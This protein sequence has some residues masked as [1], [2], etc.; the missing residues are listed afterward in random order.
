[1]KLY[2]YAIPDR[3]DIL[4]D[5]MI[6]FTQPAAFNDP[7]EMSPY[8]AAIVSEDYIAARMA[9]DHD[10]HVAESYNRLSRE[11]RRKISFKQYQAHFS[12]DVM[13]KKL[14]EKALGPALDEARESLP[15]AINQAL[16]IL[17]LTETSDDLLM[18]AHYA[19]S[20]SGMVLEFDSE[21]D[22]FVRQFPEGTNVNPV[23]FDEDLRKDYGFLRHIDYSKD[24]PAL[25]ISDVKS[26]AAFLVKSCEWSY[27]R[28]WR[29]L[30][31]FSYADKKLEI[32]GDWPVC[33]FAIPL[34]AIT[35][36]I[37]GTRAEP[38]LEAEVKAIVSGNS[39]ARH[40]VLE[41]M[42]LDPKEFKLRP[43]HVPIS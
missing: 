31:P 13:I 30:M 1:M 34:S 17:C 20:H 8:L 32:E 7:F 37:L 4:R 42:S 25:T 5:G 9:T 22:F 12:K 35:K 40:I 6:R 14:R 18:W 3:I 36:V 29:M 11:I 19:E 21:H 38:S 24:R 28:E 26:F 2:K 33:L 16:G 23:G 41:R 10:P 27:E 39:A 43:V 15:I